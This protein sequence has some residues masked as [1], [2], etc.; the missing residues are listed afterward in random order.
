MWKPVI[1]VINRDAVMLWWAQQIQAGVNSVIVGH[2]VRNIWWYWKCQQHVN[3]K[4]LTLGNALNITSFW[5]IIAQEY[6]T[7]ASGSFL[8]WCFT[9]CTSAGIHKNYKDVFNETSGGGEQSPRKNAENAGVA[10][11]HEADTH[12]FHFCL[13]CEWHWEIVFFWI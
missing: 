2:R 9:A 7:K 13:N 6:V 5:S 8:R 3:M 4:N 10:L 11:N 12:S 1:I